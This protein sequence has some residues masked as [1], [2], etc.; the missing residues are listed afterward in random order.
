MGHP[1]DPS[2]ELAQ[3]EALF[4]QAVAERK[5]FLEENICG[6]LSN[7][8]TSHGVTEKVALTFAATLAG[9]SD[10]EIIQMMH[11]SCWNE[12]EKLSEFISKLIDRAID[13]TAEQEAMEV[14]Q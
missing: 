6:E 11:M 7:A 5:K 13:K 14:M 8:G 4:E 3:E 2:T 10:T 1:N 9:L 12:Q